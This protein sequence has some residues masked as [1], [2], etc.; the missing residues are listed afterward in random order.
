MVS[1]SLDHK[2]RRV[3]VKIFQQASHKKCDTAISK[4]EI[5]GRCPEAGIAKPTH[6]FTFIQSKITTL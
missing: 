2:N 1:A 4:M 6:A 5:E 3:V